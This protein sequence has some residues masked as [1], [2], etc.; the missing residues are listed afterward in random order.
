[1]ELPDE[2]VSYQY[3]SLVLPSGEEWTPAAELRSRHY[4]HPSRLKDLMPRLLQAKSQVAAEREA[5]NVPAESL[6]IH[7][8]FID[9][10]QSFL[11]GFRR[12]GEAS[13]LGRIQAL[14][15]RLREQA[16]RVIL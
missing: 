6:P 13:D 7:A 2:A 10:P 11:D 5:R 16:D 9:L 4:L 8:G 3:Q 12:K 14:A 1:M 15:A